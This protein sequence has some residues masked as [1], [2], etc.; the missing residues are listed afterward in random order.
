MGIRAKPGHRHYGESPRGTRSWRYLRHQNDVAVAERIGLAAQLD[1]K[2]PLTREHAS[3]RSRERGDRAID[4]MDA[5][6]SA[7]AD[8]AFRGESHPG[9]RAGEHQGL[10]LSAVVGVEAAVGALDADSVHWQGPVVVWRVGNFG[11]KHALTCGK[12]AP[13]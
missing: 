8:A 5:A 4:D 13:S 1:R 11:A 12:A 9:A 3:C 10:A 6:V 7:V 2:R